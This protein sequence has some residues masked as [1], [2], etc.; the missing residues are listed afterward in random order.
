MRG[1]VVSGQIKMVL[2]E[3]SCG[4]VNWIKLAQDKVPM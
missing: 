2:T 4:D 1:F 3:M